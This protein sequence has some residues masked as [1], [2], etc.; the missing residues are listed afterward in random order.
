M[1]PTAQPTA[2]AA[3][4]RTTDCGGAVELAIH[5]LDESAG[6]TTALQIVLGHLIG[7]GQRG[8]RQI[9][10][11]DGVVDCGTVER[12]VGSRHQPVGSNMPSSAP[13]A[14]RLAMACNR[15]DRAGRSPLC[16]WC[17]K[18]LKLKVP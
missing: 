2:W 11:K 17:H 5:A 15:P 6:G 14:G 12:I 16:R 1:G 4:A 9:I 10:A 7:Q 13:F 18:A 3:A 8:H